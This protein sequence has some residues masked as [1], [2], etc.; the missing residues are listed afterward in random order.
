M[1]LLNQSGLSVIID[2][3]ESTHIRGAQIRKTPATLEA[4]FS[5]AE[6]D[7]DGLLEIDARNSV[8]GRPMTLKLAPA[9]FQDPT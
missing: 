3:L 1:K 2:W 7:S 9:H 4:W 5:A 6:Q 8:Y